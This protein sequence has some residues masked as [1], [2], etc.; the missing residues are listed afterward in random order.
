MALALGIL[1]VLAALVP[2]LVAYW[3]TKHDTRNKLGQAEADELAAGMDR[4]D[5]LFPPAPQG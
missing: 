5:K 1:S 3:R 4:V 2:V